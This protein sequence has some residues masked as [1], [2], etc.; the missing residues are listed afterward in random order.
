MQLPFETVSCLV[1]S[2]RREDDYRN[3]CFADANWLV[4]KF[5]E[6][7]V[8]SQPERCTRFIAGAIAKI[9]E[10]LCVHSI[11]INRRG[12]KRTYQGKGWSFIVAHFSLK[13]SACK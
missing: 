9:I 6:E 1:P 13:T 12:S 10:Y 11:K 7:Q 5:T 3:K 2:L 8:L 4:I